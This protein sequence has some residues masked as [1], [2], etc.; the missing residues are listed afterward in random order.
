MASEI[1]ICNLALSHIG[2]SATVS[3]IDPPEGSAQAEYCATYYPIARDTLLEMHAWGFAVQ[4]EK[5]AKMDHSNPFWQYCY[6]VPNGCMRILSVMRSASCLNT[7][8]VQYVRE[9]SID[10]QQLIYANEAD[11]YVRYTV[12]IKDPTRFSPL[13]VLALSWH[14]ASMLAGV[15]IKGETGAQYGAMCTAQMNNF[16]QQAKNSDGLQHQQAI[17]HIAPWIEGR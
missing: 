6:A 8:P 10:G 16:L 4:T 3:S 5:L 11:L 17:N 12:N 1:D 7:P 14:L 15:V 13:F 9:R 2:D